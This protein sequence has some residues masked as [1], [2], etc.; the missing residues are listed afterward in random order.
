[1]TGTMENPLVSIITCTR[2]SAATIT[3]TIRSVASQQYSPLEHIIIDGGS[4]DDTLNK[5]EKLR[6][7]YEDGKSLHVVSGHD[8]GIYFGM[9]KGISIATGSVIGFLNS[10]D[11]FS[12]SHVLGILMEAFRPDTDAVHANLHYISRRKPFRTVRRYS[13]RFFSR[14]MMLLG[15]MPAHPTFYCRREYFSRFG[16]FDTSMP[17]AADFD[18][19]LRMIYCGRINTR[20]VDIDAVT[21]RTGGASTRGLTSLRSIMRDHLRAY[22][23][24]HVPANRFTD[25]IRYLWKAGEFLSALFKSVYTT[26]QPSGKSIL[27]L[28]CTNPE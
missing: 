14:R 20:Y 25:S 11:Y 23:K 13:S 4:T 21:M 26:K 27:P 10:D 1:M 7:V 24:N 12:S 9:N 5:V 16:V 8:N 6:P 22:H 2:N 17:V 15:F 18:L 28:Q 3:D 19:M